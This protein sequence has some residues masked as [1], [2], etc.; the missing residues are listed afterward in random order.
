[1]REKNELIEISKHLYYEY[2]MFIA[3]T[4]EMITGYPPGL[5][6]N[7]L[8]QSFTVHVRNLVDFLYPKDKPQKDDVIA[9]HFFYNSEDWLRFRPPITILLKEA[10]S[11]T[12]KEMAHLTYSRLNITP[13]Q[14]RWAFSNIAINM[15][16]CFD[17]FIKNVNR[18]LLHS[19]W[20]NFFKFR[21]NF[22]KNL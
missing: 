14:K 2:S 5:I 6:N 15:R 9:E 12:N 11:R 3:I 18:D 22:K 7:A 16:D 4:E 8:L 20:N 10:K 13:L 21:D 17:V 19:D 1:M